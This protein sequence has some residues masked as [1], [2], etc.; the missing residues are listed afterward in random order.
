[1]TRR[2]LHH[3]SPSYKRG[4]VSILHVGN[5]CMTASF[6]YEDG[7]SVPI[8][9]STVPSTFIGVPPI[10]EMYIRVRGVSIL[11]QFPRFSN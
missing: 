6:Q 8:S 5:T 9:F 11:S 4:Y 1:M 7:V 2:S 3:P 10:Q